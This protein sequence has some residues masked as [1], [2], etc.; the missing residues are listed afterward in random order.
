M[1]IDFK[2][3]GKEFR[4]DIETYV[5]TWVAE[6]LRRATTQRIALVDSTVKRAYGIV[7]RSLQEMREHQHSCLQT[8]RNHT[9]LSFSKKLA[10]PIEGMGSPAVTAFF[11]RVLE[12]YQINAKLEVVSYHSVTNDVFLG[13]LATGA[14]HRVETTC[15]WIKDNPYVNGNFGEDERTSLQEEL[16]A[17]EWEAAKNEVGTDFILSLAESDDLAASASSSSSS[18][19]L[20][21]SSSSSSSSSTAVAQPP[22]AKLLELHVH[23]SKLIIHSSFFK[24]ALKPCPSFDVP[25]TEFK[26][27]PKVCSLEI[28][29]LLLEFIYLGEIKSTQLDATQLVSLYKAADFYRMPVALKWVT[30]QLKDAAFHKKLLEAHL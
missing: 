24:E 17:A 26:M 5:D 11:T 19:S 1:P 27:N 10:A 14:G 28:F 23:K 20:S 8:D 16:S 22:A 7:N 4:P 12:K 25:Q 15:Q 9:S 6:P 29:Q 13:N 30:R 18:S 21:S 2:E 3:F